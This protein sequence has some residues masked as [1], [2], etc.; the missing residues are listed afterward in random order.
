MPDS[1]IVANIREQNTKNNKNTVKVD[2]HVV[3]VQKMI[4]HQHKMLFDITRSN[5]GF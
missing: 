3:F 4:A 5:L 2:P 1:A